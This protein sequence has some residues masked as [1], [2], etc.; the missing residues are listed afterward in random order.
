MFGIYGAGISAILAA[1]LHCSVAHLPPVREVHCDNLGGSNVCG[2][3][4]GC[5]NSV[6]VTCSGSL[7]ATVTFT[8]TCTS[9]TWGTTSSVVPVLQSSTE[10]VGNA[11]GCK[12]TPSLSRTWGGICGEGDCCLCFNISCT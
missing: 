10:S 5:T 6:S 3:S 9:P 4:S 8:T 12:I 1:I 2:G 11:C 7:I